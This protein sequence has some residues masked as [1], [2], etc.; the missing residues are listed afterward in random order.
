MEWL[1]NGRPHNGEVVLTLT[2][3]DALYLAGC[4]E[5]GISPD[6]RP[7]LVDELIHLLRQAAPYKESA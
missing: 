7:T 3:D 1:T 5:G 4:I 2:E 6:R